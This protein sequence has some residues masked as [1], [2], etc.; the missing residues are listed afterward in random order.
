[1]RHLVVAVSSAVALVSWLAATS[2]GAWTVFVSGTIYQNNQVDFAGLFGPPGANLVGKF[3]TQTITTDPPLNATLACSSLSC[4]GTIGGGQFGPGAQ[5]TITTTVNGVPYTQADAAPFLNYA[6][7]IN[8]LSINDTTTTLQDQVYQGI[9]S[10]GCS[11]V[12]GVCTDAYIL[13]YSLETPFVPRLEFDQVISVSTGLDPGSNAYFRYF[14]GSGQQMAF[15]GT[16]STLAIDTSPADGLLR[17][18]KNEVIGIGPGNSLANKVALAQAY[19]EAEDI[20][21]TCPILA[22]FIRELEAQR[23]KT[24]ATDLTDKL[25]AEAMT[26]ETAVGCY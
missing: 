14:D 16:V 19:L 9:Q 8:A 3:Y 17:A 25:I 7:L 5:Y 6:Y 1:M 11:T 2:A 10:S 21:A 23:G 13:A 26:I 15:Y 22:S 12:L 18:L 4:L 24:I 20:G